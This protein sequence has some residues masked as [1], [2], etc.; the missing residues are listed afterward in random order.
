MSDGYPVTSHRVLPLALAAGTLAA[1]VLAPSAQADSNSDF[2]GALAN[3]GI[4]YANG[5][6]TTALGQ[7]LCPLLVQP[8]KS[9]A[10]AVSTV[11]N[12]GVSPDMAALFTGLAIQMYCPQMMAS[13]ADGSILQTLPGLS[14]LSILGS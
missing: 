8:G 13:V 9:F 12:K 1:A 5:A 2:L 6:D 3:A 11:R 7:S 14:G 10:S 4:G